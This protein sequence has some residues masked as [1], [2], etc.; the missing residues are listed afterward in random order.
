VTSSVSRMWTVTF[1]DA[2][3]AKIVTQ[4][5]TFTNCDF[6][7]AELDASRH[8]VT[9]FLGCTFDKVGWRGSA[10]T[11]CKLTGSVFIDCR[12]MPWTVRDCDL[13]IGVVW[14]RSA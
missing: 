6:T 10:L 1:S 4:S 5:C 13:S 11:G 12:C 2:D 7:G 8:A 14:R 9:A 3:L